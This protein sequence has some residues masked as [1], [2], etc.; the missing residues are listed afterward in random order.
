[1]RTDERGHHH[2]TCMFCNEEWIVS[3]FATEPYICP[4]CRANYKTFNFSTQKR[5]RGNQNDQH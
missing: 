5:K 1:M 3:K 4:L 2:A